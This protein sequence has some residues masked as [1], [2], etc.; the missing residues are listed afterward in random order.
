MDFSVKVHPSMPKTVLFYMDHA[1]AY[2][3]DLT[4][5]QELHSELNKF[6]PEEHQGKVQEMIESFVQECLCTVIF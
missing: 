5:K 6:I 4:P 3:P 2:V 1:M